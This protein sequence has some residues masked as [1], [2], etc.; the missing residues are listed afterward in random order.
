MTDVAVATPSFQIAPLAPTP[1]APPPAPGLGA[2][3]DVDWG[4]DAL[5]AKARKTREQRLA[6]L[7]K[8]RAAVEAR[9]TQTKAER[10][11]AQERRTYTGSESERRATHAA[12]KA[13]VEKVSPLPSDKDFSGDEFRKVR[14]TLRQRYPGRKLSDMLTEAARLEQMLIDDPV[15][16]HQILVASYSRAGHLR[17]YQEPSYDKGARGSVQRARQDQEDMQDLKEWVAKYGARV[18]KILSEL[19]ILDRELHKDPNYAAA[20]LAARH[21]APAIQAEIPAY[22]AKMAQKEHAARADR[23][24]QGVN[25]AIEHG[26]IPGDEDSLN[27]IAAV[28]SHPQFQA[29]ADGLDTLKRAA[30]IA[31][32]P[33]H[34]RITPRTP[35][36]P[37]AKSDAGTK[38]ISGAPNMGASVRAPS[39]GVRGSIDRA[40]R[41][42]R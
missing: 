36:K 11:A 13:A 9:P 1:V 28:L 32:H 21:G 38:S 33:D 34:V 30:A 17:G 6:A 41:K 25:L 5:D 18:P 40:I 29:S 39:T 2:R 4:K 14:E 27:E 10:L 19:E 24:L 26:R 12:V 31:A 8:A 20:K 37:A 23:V 35:A 7:R 16:A 3:I 22:Q 42:H 15:Q